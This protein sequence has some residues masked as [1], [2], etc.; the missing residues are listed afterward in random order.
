MK[1]YDAPII[2]SVPHGEDWLSKQELASLTPEKII[3]RVKAL[4]PLIAS[5]ARK[6][7]LDRKPVDEVWTELRKTGMFYWFVPKIF[8]GLEYD[9]EGF[10]DLILPIAEACPSTSW[11]S[12]FVVEHNWLFSMFPPEGQ[13]EVFSKFPYMIAPGVNNP[14]GKMVPVE[15]GYRVSGRW[16]WG[17]GVMH[18]DWAIVGGVVEGSNPPQAYWCM[19]P[20]EECVILDTWHME[21]MIG[22][23]S[24]D[25]VVEDKFIPATRCVND[26]KMRE[27]FAEGAQFHEGAIYKAP[28]LPLLSMTAAITVL[29]AARSA[30]KQFENYLKSR[31]IHMAAGGGTQADKPAAQM[32]LGRGDL[33]VKTAE[34]LIRNTASEIMRIARSGRVATASERMF[35]RAQNA[36][37]VELCL[38]SLRVM[39]AGA[40][41]G[42]HNLNNPLQRSLRDVQVAAGHITFD[43]DLALEQ[44]ARLMLGLDSTSGLN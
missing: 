30:V 12:S 14:P 21:G 6:A 16:K 23:G 32:R 25:I 15:G 9:A 19:L 22:T 42:A 41:A 24:N 33:Q 10:I 36:Y 40:G 26:V 2:K 18:A 5:H 20:I 28:M 8:G 27:G 17:T 13:R 29:G 31:R 43:M 35:L 3:D 1:N 34:K 38:D 39:I 7:E 11:S 44:H 4:Q 37:A